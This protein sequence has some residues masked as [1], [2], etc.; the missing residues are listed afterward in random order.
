M[1]S[2]S[3][4]TTP[5]DADPDPTATPRAQRGVI[6]SGFRVVSLFTLLSRVMGLARDMLMAG[7]FGAGPLMDSFSVAFRV[8]NVFRR[9]F[10]EGALT[11][12]FLPVFV[13]EF[14]RSGTDAA[15]RLT[16]AVFV[17][18]SSVLFGIVLSA[19]LLL[20]GTYYFLPVGSEGRTLIALTAEMLPYAV[21][22]CL[23]AQLSAVLH[24]LQRFAWPAFAPVLLN[25]IWMVSASVVAL[26][27]DDPDRRIHVIAWSI[28]AAGVIQL[29]T[30]GIATQKAG[31]TFSPD[32]KEARPLV[33]EVVRAMMPVLFVTWITQVNTVVDGLIAWGLAAPPDYVPGR[34][35][36]FPWP[37]EA[38]TASALY[39]AQRMYQFP[40]GVFAIALGTVLFPLMS[41]HAE[42]GEF[43]QV[44]RDLTYGMRLVV[45][46]GVP[47]SV[48]LA[49]LSEP[50]A[51]LFFERGA[52]TAEDASLTARCIAAYG[53]GVWAYMGLTIIHRGFFA[54][55]DRQR[56]LSMGILAMALN[57]FLNLTL[58]WF[59]AAT[60][61]ALSTAIAAMVQ[62]FLTV[63]IYQ[64][65]NG[66]LD[67]R[68]IGATVIRTIAATA[69]MGVACLMSMSWLPG[70]E[71]LLS[72]VAALVVPIVVSIAAYAVGAKL[73]GL[74]EPFDLLGR[75]L[76]TE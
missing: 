26:L 64:R 15:N 72:R 10:G 6:G 56:P 41:K 76:S 47:A 46:I 25:I 27:T 29:V 36:G 62:L 49:L 14:D 35:E 8:P 53:I 3:V 12:A 5:E 34:D 57:T 19:E 30:I 58:I 28:L 61:L 52:F 68:S 37:L 24:S 21:L 50:I 45:A 18:M 4:Q 39:F 73:V 59:L 23:V 69:L 54:L 42:R 75:R 55:G 74:R 33:R 7:L 60:G 40:Q 44:G 9:M 22:I 31:I 66:L 16:T 1:S 63:A 38:G 20:M 32:W 13:R 71:S 65:Q 48:G 2:E 70:D 51:V 11:T 67:D 17:T 43:S